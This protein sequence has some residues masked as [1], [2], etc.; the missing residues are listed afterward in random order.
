MSD[1]SA[2]SETITFDTTCADYRAG[3]VAAIWQNPEA[4]EAV[5]IS[6]VNAGSL[7][8]DRPTVN[9]WSGRKLIMPVRIAYIPD[10]IEREDVR[11]DLVR[12]KAGFLVS[13]T[14]RLTG[15]APVMEYKGLP[16]IT[17][18]SLLQNDSL[19]GQYSRDNKVLDPGT[20]PIKMDS[21]HLYETIQQARRVHLHNR[22][23]VWNYR[24][25]LHQLA[26]RLGVVWAPSFRRDLRIGRPG[27]RG[28]R[29][30]GPLRKSGLWTTTAMTIH[31]A[32]TWRLSARTAAWCCER[33]RAWSRAIR[34]RKS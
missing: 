31:Y 6:A 5:T 29:E 33:S 24:L 32:A 19:S 25:L 26:G 15:Y 10:K 17:D 20:G 9:G 13:D 23:A 3:G 2:G 22:Q 30:P 12:L 27:R 7:D 18:P 16:V 1:V 14:I 8:L 28:R 11:T 4:F 21:W 34:G